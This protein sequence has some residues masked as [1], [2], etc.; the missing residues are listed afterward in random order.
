MDLDRLLGHDE[1][2]LSQPLPAAEHAVALP[3]GLVREWEAVAP[4][5]REYC[6]KQ[7]DPSLA[8]LLRWAPYVSRYT[9]QRETLLAARGRSSPSLK[10]EN[11]A[12]AGP[13]ARA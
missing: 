13:A 11:A 1:A 9:F 2:V 3:E 12:P 8:A 7:R 4:Q 10:T 5:L 6:S